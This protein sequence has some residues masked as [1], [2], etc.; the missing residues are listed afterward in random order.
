VKFF[1]SAQLLLLN[2]PVAIDQIE[3]VP[4]YIFSTRLVRFLL[5]PARGNSIV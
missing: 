3:S 2:S 5:E 1:V 4:V